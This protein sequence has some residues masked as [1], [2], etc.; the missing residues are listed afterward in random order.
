MAEPEE[1]RFKSI[2]PRCTSHRSSISRC[3]TLQAAVEEA[4]CGVSSLLFH[5][6]YKLQAL[7]SAFELDDCSLPRLALFFCHTAQKQQEEA[8]ELLRY[9]SQRGGTYCSRDI[10]RSGCEAVCAVLPALDLLL[11]Q[12]KE[13]VEVLVELRHMSQDSG[14]PQTCSMIQSHLLNPRLERLKQLGDLRSSA[15][16]L[17]CTTD[18][19]GGFG[20]YLFNE[21]QERLKG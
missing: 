17:G 15:Q 7:A 3:V 2:L 13:E 14:D 18:T 21:L 5:G 19:T 9:L 4:L 12:L 16:R 8:Q 10:Q 20:E 11:L 6:V 1:K